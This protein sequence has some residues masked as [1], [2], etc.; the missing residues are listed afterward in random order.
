MLT[1][2]FSILEDRPNPPAYLS[3]FVDIPD[4]GVVGVRVEFLI[5]TGADRSIISDFDA[6]RM[7]EYYGADLTNLR[8]GR[9]TRGLGGFTA[10]LTAESTLKIDDFSQDMRL[11]ILAPATETYLGVPSLLGRDVLS[12]FA[13]FVEERTDKVLLLEPAESD[14]LALE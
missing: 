6:S 5:D 8:D 7:V 11:D 9:P 10:T 14:A 3:V 4:A 13:L 2:Y 1:G 12:Q